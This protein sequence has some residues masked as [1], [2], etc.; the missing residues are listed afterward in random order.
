MFRKFLAILV[1][2]FLLSIPVFQ[3]VGTTPLP[4]DEP[5]AKTAVITACIGPMTVQVLPKDRAVVLV[6]F[7]AGGCSKQLTY[8]FGLR[9]GKI[10]A[11]PSPIKISTGT[12][13]APS[14]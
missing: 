5:L 9:F 4:V 11:S 8:G 10:T 13:K 12:S 3:S 1:G 6:A 14:F 7:A 2:F